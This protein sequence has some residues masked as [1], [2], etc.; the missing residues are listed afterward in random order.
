MSGL[1]LRAVSLVAAS[2][3]FVHYNK[4]FKMT[5]DA[6]VDGVRTSTVYKD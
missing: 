5:Y 6:L 3:S 1:V 4:T 2:R